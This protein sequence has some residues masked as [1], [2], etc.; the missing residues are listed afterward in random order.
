[1][2]RYDPPVWSGPT[3]VFR[4][5]LRVR[6][7]L[8]SCTYRAA[9]WPRRIVAA[10]NF[11]PGFANSGPCLGFRHLFAEARRFQ[12]LSNEPNPGLGEVCEAI[13]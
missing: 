11:F 4:K 6:R 1:M 2:P 10:M 12:Q 9:T 7:F 5:S 3:C 13:L 8:L